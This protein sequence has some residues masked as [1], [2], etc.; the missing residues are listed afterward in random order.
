MLI[1]VTAP[2]TIPFKI[3]LA[4]WSSVGLG[5]DEWNVHRYKQLHTEDLNRTNEAIK[6]RMS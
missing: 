6:Q 1:A 2:I 3:G 4:I 5:A